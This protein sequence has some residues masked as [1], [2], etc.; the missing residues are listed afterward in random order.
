[1]NQMDIFGQAGRTQQGGQGQPMV[2]QQ[3]GAPGVEA[4][5][6]SSGRAVKLK[7]EH[8]ALLGAFGAVVIGAGWLLLGGG[9]DESDIAIVSASPTSSPTPGASEAQ[10]SPSAVPS[11]TADGRNPFVVSSKGS[12]SGFSGGVAAT[13]PAVNAPVAVAPTVTVTATV[14]VRATPTVS[15]PV[16]TTVTKTVTKTLSPVYVVLHTWDQATE[17]AKIVVNDVPYRLTKDAATVAGVT[18]VG[19]ADANDPAKCIKVKPEGGADATIKAVC[20]GD[21]IRLS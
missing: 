14:R 16:P 9:S 17:D 13:T 19:P 3:S 10:N 8:L 21:G 1:M 6:G 4:P 18:Y 2:P 5:L 12:G 11:S 15:V 7:R 20:V